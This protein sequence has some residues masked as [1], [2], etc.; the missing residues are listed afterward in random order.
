MSLFNKLFVA[1]TWS[2]AFRRE[3]WKW[4]FDYAIAFETLNGDKGY[5][6]ADP[7]I[8]S[9]SNTL[10]LFCEAFSLKKQLGEIAVFSYDG[11]KW[12]KPQV[13]ISNNYHM[14]YPC[15]FK[16]KGRYYMIPETQEVKALELY[17]CSIFPY[18]WEKR[19][20]L[21]EGVTIADPTVFEKEGSLYVIGQSGNKSQRKI[22]LYSLDIDEN[23]VELIYQKECGADVCRPAGY[24]ISKEDAFIRPTQDCRDTYGKS[25]I[26][27]YF[28]LTD[29]GFSEK[30]IGSIENSRIIIGNHM[31]VDRIHTFSRAGNI[32]VI[33][34]SINRFDLF[35]RFRILWRQYKRQK[36]SLR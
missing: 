6:Y 36:R 9:E 3:E 1:G 16:Q 22:H 15:V 33:D 19:G 14:S 8:I 10:Y 2:I 12:S 28:S 34:Y 13:I 27:N 26:W 31:G 35:K 20:A 4:P 18:K 24:L 11:E 17:E 32:E 30:P 5:W 7:M 29:G 21:L 23:K 25:V